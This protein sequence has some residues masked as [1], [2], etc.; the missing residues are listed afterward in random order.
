MIEWVGKKLFVVRNG[1]F[2]IVLIDWVCN[3]LH[4][5]YM[6]SGHFSRWENNSFL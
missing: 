1:D 3:V 2:V 6:V 4:I 5:L